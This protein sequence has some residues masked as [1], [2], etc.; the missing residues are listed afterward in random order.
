MSTAEILDE[1]SKLTPSE[2]R[3][4]AERLLELDRGAVVLRSRGLDVPAAAELR[5]R[6]A[7]FADDWGSPEME[8]Y[9]DYDAAKAKL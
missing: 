6:L 4:I 5:A 9:D 3:Q 1:L 8:S 7:V 2:R